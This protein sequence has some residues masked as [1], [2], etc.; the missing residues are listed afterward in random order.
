MDMAKLKLFH[1][2]LLLGQIFAKLGIKDMFKNA[3]YGFKQGQQE[4]NGSAIIKFDSAENAK[5]ACEKLNN[6]KIDQKHTIKTYTVQDFEQ[7]LAQSDE[8]VKPR[9]ITDQ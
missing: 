1:E 4:T 3:D 5:V 7:I 2:K 8:Y 6:V 9:C